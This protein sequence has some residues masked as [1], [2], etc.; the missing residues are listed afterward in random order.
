MPDTRPAT[1]P[2]IF[3]GHFTECLQDL[4]ARFNQA[5]PPKSRNRIS[6]LKRMTSFCGVAL[7][8]PRR[9]FLDDAKV[10]GEVYLRLVFFLDIN[11]YKVIEL[12]RM[13][14]SVVRKVAELVA[15]NVITV[16]ELCQVVGFAQQAEFFAIF[17]GDRGTSKERIN[18]MWELIQEHRVAVYDK[19]KEAVVKYRLSFLRKGRVPELKQDNM[20]SGEVAP[21]VMDESPV[22]SGG[23][24]VEQETVQQPSLSL[25]GVRKSLIESMRGV[26]SGIETGIF[27]GVSER[28]LRREDLETIESLAFLLSKLSYGLRRKVD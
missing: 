27:I 7:R 16:D 23:V 15:F 22:Q 3:R 10:V 9:W 5:Y 26:K 13:Q 12:E 6:H 24:V 19:Q 28:D 4:G 8:T 14:S 17:R 21:T 11:G 20:I 18:R 2:E 25:I 1:V